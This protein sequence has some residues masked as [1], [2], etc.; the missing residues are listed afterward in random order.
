MEQTNSNVKETAEN[1]D[2]IIKIIDEIKNDLSD[3]EIVCFLLDKKNQTTQ[4]KSSEKLTF[5]QKAA[6]SVANFVGS[7]NFIICFAGMLIF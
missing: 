5:G 3:E 6:D 2:L 1:S 4:T 7:W